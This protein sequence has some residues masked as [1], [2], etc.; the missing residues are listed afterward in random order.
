MQDRRLEERLL[1]ADFVSVQWRDGA[2]HAREA[3]ANLED[4]SPSGVCL[5]LD[6]PIRRGALVRVVHPKGE[7]EGI[8]KYCIFRDLGYFMGIKF[9]A[10]YTWSRRRFKPKHLLDLRRLANRKTQARGGTPTD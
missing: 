10:G 3:L 8:V 5:Q 7:M 1:C 6:E 4:I 2:G 9:G